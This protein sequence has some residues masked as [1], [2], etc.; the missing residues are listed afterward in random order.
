MRAL[1]LIDIQNDFL[2]T[3]SLPVREGDQVIAVANTLIGKK[4]VGKF[5]YVVATQDW[6]PK[7]HLSFAVMHANRKIGEFIELEG[8]QQILWPEHCVQNSSG[9]SFA[10]GL[11]VAGVDK[12]VQK[13]TKP[14][15]D[16]YSGFFD[17]ARRHQTELDQWL[18]QKNINELVVM[19]L[20]TD[21]CVKFT[22]L[23]A[24]NLGF[25]VTVISDGCRGVN[26]HPQD[27]EKAFREMESKGAKVL[28]LKEFIG[29]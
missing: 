29:E 10:D 12:V 25:K 6:H 7:E 4:G 21:Y 28:A 3:G 16:S 20:A 9:A 2:P 13:G 17:N 24:L 1:L 23:D 8:L 26:I 22:V 27:S 18:R 15:I 19:G 14:S 5:D 11:N